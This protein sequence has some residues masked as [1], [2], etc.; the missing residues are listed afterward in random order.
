MALAI[1]QV[2]KLVTKPFLTVHFLKVI[3]ESIWAISQCPATEEA[4]NRYVTSIF[5]G[6]DDWE[7][8]PHTIRKLGENPEWKNM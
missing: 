5:P 6:Q 8:C 3:P 4:E 2:N 7:V 1:L